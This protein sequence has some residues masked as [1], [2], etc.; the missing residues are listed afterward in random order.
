MGAAEIEA[1]LLQ[2][3][4]V[5]SVIMPAFSLDEGGKAVRE[6]GWRLSIRV[7]AGVSLHIP[8]AGLSDSFRI[9]IAPTV[10]DCWL[11][12]KADAASREGD[13]EDI[14]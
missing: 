13:D 14:L 9:F 8:Q 6:D 3:K 10:A 2:Q 4:A 5:N 1:F 11:A 7:P 12:A